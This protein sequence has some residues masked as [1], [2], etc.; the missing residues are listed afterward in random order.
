MRRT[1]VAGDDGTPYRPSVL[2]ASTESVNVR[3]SDGDN[4]PT[5][6]I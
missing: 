1:Y 6:T 2:N 5:P 4:A 3:D